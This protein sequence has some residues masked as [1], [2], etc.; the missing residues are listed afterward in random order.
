MALIENS[1]A[2]SDSGLYRLSDNGHA[3][4]LEGLAEIGRG[5]VASDK[6]VKEVFKKL[7]RK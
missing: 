1:R 6:E 4:I 2:G 3:D 7:R 5:E